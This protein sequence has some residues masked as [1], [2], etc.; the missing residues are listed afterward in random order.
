M[1]ECTTW[2]DLIRLSERL[3]LGQRLKATM[4]PKLN[5]TAKVVRRYE[6]MSLWKSSETNFCDFSQLRVQDPFAGQK[7][8]F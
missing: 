7:A 8:D 6:P 3:H 1:P 2:W 5:R 4:I